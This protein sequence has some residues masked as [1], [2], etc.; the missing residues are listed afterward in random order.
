MLNRL[1][2]WRERGW[3]PIN[4]ADYAEVW[5]RFGGSVAT[6][7]EVV[8]RLADLAGIPV[9]YLGWQSGGE[10]KAAIPTWGRHLALSKDV[11]KQQGKRGLFDLGNAEIILPLAADAHVPLRHRVRYL[12]ELNVAQLTGISEQPEGLAL[13]RE[14]EQYS[15]KFRYNQRREQRL[16]EEAGGV[17]RPM[18]ELTPEEQARI[19]ADLFQRRWGFEA[20]GKD[21]LAEVFALLREFMTGSL[22]YLN[23]EPVAIQVLYRVEAPQ[24]VSLEYINGGVDPQ[25][26]EFSP[27]SVLSFVNTQSEWEHARALGKPLRYSFGRADREYKDRWCNRVPVY[28]V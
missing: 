4:A 19:Y 13:A 14:P 23:D 21:H 18:L 25:Q 10:L 3:T 9:R 11:L 27:G 7:P 12:S 20:T 8:A 1:Q 24:W 16:L 26:R 2:F 5:A 17:I 6:H 15:K 22:I 28:Q